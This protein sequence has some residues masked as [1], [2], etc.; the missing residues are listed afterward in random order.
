[1]HIID[2]PEWMRSARCLDVDPD[3]FF[4]E[5][6]GSTKQARALCAEC[7]VATE[8]LQYALDDLDAIDNGIWGDTSPRERREIKRTRRKRAIRRVA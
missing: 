6:G 3:A 7:R 8:C 2:P 1:M 4:P 5:R